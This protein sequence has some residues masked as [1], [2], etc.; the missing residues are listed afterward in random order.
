MQTVGID[1]YAHSVALPKLRLCRGQDSESHI[2]D[3]QVVK[4]GR[5]QFLVEI[6]C[7]RQLPG[8][9]CA[10][11]HVFRPQT[12]LNQRAVMC[13]GMIAG[14]FDACT[15]LQQDR[16]LFFRY[17]SGQKI[18]RGRPDEPRNIDRGRS[19]IDLF[20]RAHLI[21][22]AL[23]HDHQTVGK[24]H[25]FVLVMRDE[26]RCRLDPIVNAA[27]LMAHLNPQLGIEIR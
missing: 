10:E 9:R 6:K 17:L 23:V 3:Y 7:P 11:R 16:G 24:R 1:H 5:S 20:R 14:D 4:P 2:L 13:A 15:V 8:T 12:K 25:A 27:D 22:R 19:I 26:N 18:H 21:N